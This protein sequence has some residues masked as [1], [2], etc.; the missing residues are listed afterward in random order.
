ML[1]CYDLKEKS[2]ELQQV[3]VYSYLLWLRA[4]LDNASTVGALEFRSV[5]SMLF[6]RRL[7]L[8]DQRQWC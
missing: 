7:A 3:E 2:I 4:S 6:L 8:S 1:C 5:A